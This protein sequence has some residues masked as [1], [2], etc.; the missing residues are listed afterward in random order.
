MMVIANSISMENISV[1]Q[2]IQT[3]SSAE[4]AS[5]KIDWIHGLIPTTTQLEQLFSKNIYTKQGRCISPHHIP[6]ANI[7]KVQD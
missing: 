4:R 5:K 6:N 2:L 3:R 1:M 7:W